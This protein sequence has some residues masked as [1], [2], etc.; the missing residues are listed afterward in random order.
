MESHTFRRLFSS[1]VGL[2][3]NQ[4]HLKFTPAGPL[5][6]HEDIG[7]AYPPLYLNSTP[8]VTTLENSLMRVHR[9]VPGLVALPFTRL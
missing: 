3:K 4:R 5:S 7:P 8:I 9:K 2:L 1:V 6:S